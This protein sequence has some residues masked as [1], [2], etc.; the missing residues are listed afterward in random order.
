MSWAKDEKG[1]LVVDV[2]IKGENSP[3]RYDA[4]FNSAPLGAMQW[5]DLS[6]LNLNRG[7][8]QAIRSLGH[9]ASCKVGIRFQNLWWI[10]HSGIDKGGIAKTDLPLRI[11]VHPSYNP[12]D[13]NPNDDTDKPGVLLCSHTS[14]QRRRSI[15][16]ESLQDEEEPTTLL[17]DSLA[18]WHSEDRRPRGS[19]KSSPTPTRRATRTTG[20]PMPAPR[21]R[22][23]TSTPAFPQRVPV[24]HAQQW[25]AHDH[26]ES[27]LDTL[28]PAVRGVYQSLSAHSANSPAAHEA[29]QLYSLTQILLGGQTQWSMCA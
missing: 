26:W 10:K 29:L 28:E 11:C 7:T 20:T 13:H 15:A 1:D 17:I 23:R 5:V 14:G 16:H 18:K 8:K 6:G 21:A 12:Q 2:T 27:G 9:G 3:H 22:S 19:T 25:A 24:D 4:V